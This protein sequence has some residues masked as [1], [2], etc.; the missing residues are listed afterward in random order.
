MS[1][2]FTKRELFSKHALGVGVGV[3]ALALLAQT[4]NVAAQT[5]FTTFPFPATGGPKARTMPDRLAEVKNVK[6]FGAVGDGVTDDTLAI[7]SAVNA[8][9]N[10][11]GI[12]FFPPG[13]YLISSPITFVAGGE[14]S[15]IFQGVGVASTILGSFSD[16]LIKI[17]GGSGVG[18]CFYAQDLSLHNY[19]A[20]GGGIYFTGV[21]GSGVFRCRVQAFHG[22]TQDPYTEQFAC[23]DCTF[24]GPPGT[25]TGSWGVMTWGSGAVV[26]SCIF[27]AIDNCIRAAG[28]GFIFL[29]NRLE[30]NIK[31]GMMLGMDASGTWQSVAN[32]SIISCTFE[33]CS[34]GIDAI[35]LSN[36]S[37]D[38][39][40]LNLTTNAYGSVGSY[41]IRIRNGGNYSIKNTGINQSGIAY[42]VAGL[43]IESQSLIAT[44]ENTSFPSLKLSDPR[45]SPI[46]INCGVSEGRQPT[47][48]NSKP[49]SPV[50]GMQYVF[51]DST[52]NSF[53]ATVAGGG[54][55]MVAAVYGGDGVWRVTQQ[56][57]N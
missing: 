11:A 14:S 3:G 46:F 49:I 16:Y 1:T 29:N 4:Q 25:P 51:T 55:H 43:S 52:T 19:G 40:Q 54:T 22:V 8:R 47:V 57:S 2:D 56:L 31:T 28:G 24:F 5:A 13:T 50:Q 39:C 23:R 7:Q 48:Y 42:S 33:A 36:S 37:I 6:D 17:S 10:M 35:A 34:V 26:D 41:G 15:I 38:N 53:G 45:F 9:G 44:I 27:Q 21:T 12:I 30:G 20:S 32:C 18:E